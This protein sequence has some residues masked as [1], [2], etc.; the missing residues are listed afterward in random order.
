M[1]MPTCPADL[2]DLPLS[3]MVEGAN[4]RPPLE[5][6]SPDSRP[7][8]VTETPDVDATPERT[9]T[10]GE[11]IKQF[12]IRRAV[13]LSVL[14]SV[15]VVLSWGA[16][17]H[18]ALDLVSHFPL[19]IAITA[20]VPLAILLGFRRWKVAMVPA[21]VLGVCVAQLLPL[22]FPAR[23][24]SYSG[25]VIHAISVNVLRRNRQH[26][27]FIEYIRANPPDFFLLIEVDETWIAGRRATNA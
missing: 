17:L 11:W 8:N 26:A 21:L 23:Q 22:Y 25:E 7:T 2:N 5:H 15:V 16:R 9:G 19:Q 3:G 24:P 14:L 20:L 18:W 12:I 13:T 1:H 6:R 4:D 27:K 10:T